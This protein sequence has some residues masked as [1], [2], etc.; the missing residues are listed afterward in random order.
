MKYITFAL[1]TTLAVLQYTIWMDGGGL[2]KE[3]AE[4]HQAANTIHKQ[5]SRQ[6]AANHALRAEVEDLQNGYDA[7]VE[8]TRSEMGYIQDG[9]TFYRTVAE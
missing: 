3:Y 5:N 2:R 6:R 9:E 8:I 4:K 7:I 1:L